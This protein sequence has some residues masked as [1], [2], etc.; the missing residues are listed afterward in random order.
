MIMTTGEVVGVVVKAF[1]S[2]S[3][4]LCSIPDR[5]ILNTLKVNIPNFSAWRSARN[6]WCGKKVD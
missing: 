1:A 5:A 4:D 2:L 6:G 3:D